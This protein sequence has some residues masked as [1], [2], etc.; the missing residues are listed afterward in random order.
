MVLLLILL[1]I[2]LLGLARLSLGL[3]LLL[4]HPL[5]CSISPATNIKSIHFIVK[6]IRAKI[7]DAVNIIVLICFVFF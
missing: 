3:L 2:L 4:L 1:L 5:L 6:G 7:F